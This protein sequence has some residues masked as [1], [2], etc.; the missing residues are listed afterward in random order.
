MILII[1]RGKARETDWRHEENGDWSWAFG[2]VCT[3]VS[4]G[5]MVVSNLIGFADTPNPPS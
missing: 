4:A 5:A 3:L 1:G 2:G